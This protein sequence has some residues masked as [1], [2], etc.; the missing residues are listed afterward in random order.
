M[1]V[2]IDV[3]SKPGL[4]S[5]MREFVSL[6]CLEGLCKPVHEALADIRKIELNDAQVTQFTTDAE[7]RGIIL[8]RVR[9]PGRQINVT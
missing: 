1:T 9:N 2:T 4:L 8:A 5:E 6:K 3:I 7:F